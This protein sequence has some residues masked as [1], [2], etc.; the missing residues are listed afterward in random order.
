[1]KQKISGRIAM[2]AMRMIATLLMVGVGASAATAQPEKPLREQLVGAWD[3]IIAE[4]VTAD[5]KK[6]F[7]FGERPRGMLIFTAGGQFS[8][9]HVSGDLPRIASNNRL[10]GTPE[11]NAAIVHGS[12]ALFGTY[13]VDE[14]KKTLTFHIAASTFP[15]QQGTSQTR[16]IDKLTADEFVNTNPAASR[17]VPAV[18]SNRYRRAK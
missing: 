2:N 14:A 3:F 8:Q 15:N 16:T 7:P 4:I 13:T 9:V 1:M 5:S 11:Q 10:A 18:A 12:L 17:D 6:S